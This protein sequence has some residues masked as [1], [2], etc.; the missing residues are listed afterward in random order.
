MDNPNNIERPGP[1]SL[2]AR[3]MTLACLIVF[4][5]QMATTVYL[6]S[7]PI[8]MS[9]LAMT[10]QHAELSISLFVIGAD[11]P[12]LFWGAAADRFGRRLPLA[13]SLLLFVGISLL[14]ATTSQGPLLLV[15]RT[16]QGIAAGGATIIARILIR[17]HWQG[18][19]LARRLSVLSIAFITA[20]GG[21]QWIGGL[22]SR[23]AHWQLGFVLVAAVGMVAL[24]LMIRLP[25]QGPNAAAPTT[26]MWR[27]YASLLQRPGF[28]WPA[29]AGGLG[30]AITVTLQEIS[31]FVLQQ[32]FA[33][34]VTTFGALGL[35]IGVAYFAGAMAVN[36]QVARVGG[37]RLMRQG[38]GLILLAA[39]GMVVLSMLSDLQGEGVLVIMMG[40]YCLIIF[41]QAVLFPNSMALAVSDAREHGAYA[42]ALCGFL[43]QGL[44]GIAA[45]GATLLSHHGTWAPAIFALALVAALIV[46]FKVH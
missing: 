9:D 31:P 39:A 13:L 43:Q 21:G 44:A 37:K 35:L 19:E 33:L 12:L 20:L 36:R 16:L 6:P 40:L 28:L 4:M 10:R 30:F 41:G 26:G 7:L 46:R 8:V 32:G 38:A 24:A 18:D 45:A 42:M 15:L 11:L 27:R 1:W 3:L 17:D 34:E 14:L 23:Y 22:I 29:C 5:A 2:S 25:L